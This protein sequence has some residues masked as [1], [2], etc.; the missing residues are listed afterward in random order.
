[1]G[2]PAATLALAIALLT[3][4]CVGASTETTP[5]IAGSTSTTSTTSTTI[6]PTTTTTSPAQTVG[7]EILTLQIPPGHPGITVTKGDASVDRGG[8]DV[9]AAWDLDPA[10][11]GF[12]PPITATVALDGFDGLDLLWLAVAGGG[13]WS[14]APDI[15]VAETPNGA[16][17]TTELPQTGRTALVRGPSLAAWP[18]DLGEVGVGTEADFDVV[19]TS[20]R[21]TY[22]FVTAIDVDLEVFG[23]ATLVS[24]SRD[25][26]MPATLTLRCDDIGAVHTH[27]SIDVT[28]GSSNGTWADALG[29]W[30]GGLQTGLGGLPVDPP[31]SWRI[32][33]EGPG[34]TVDCIYVWTILDDIDGP[35]ASVSDRIDVPVPEGVL[36]ETLTNVGVEPSDCSADTTVTG[37]TRLAGTCGAASVPC[38]DLVVETASGR[39]PG[40]DGPWQELQVEI[41]HADG[42]TTV[43]WDRFLQGR[44]SVG[45]Q[46]LGPRD[47]EVPSA[48][49]PVPG[50]GWLGLIDCEV[51]GN[52]LEVV[53]AIAATYGLP[54][55]AGTAD[56]LRSAYLSAEGCAPPAPP[57]SIS[58]WAFFAE[59]A[60]GRSVRVDLTDELE[61]GLLEHL[62]GRGIWVVELQ[63]TGFSAEE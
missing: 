36:C 1:M 2:R 3:A 52:G 45:C 25:G 35:M 37:I 39:R 59:E 22:G 4:G 15:E 61:N 20:G 17:V 53:E 49:L 21:S 27:M 40:P 26:T 16:L 48:V 24:T 8:V 7:D 54:G 51:A 6:A 14:I 47:A 55:T 60:G 23:P 56:H 10:G 29:G 46:T 18:P 33:A 12:E 32:T 38:T 44:R 58:L 13:S 50:D 31:A 30:F 63:E 62:T 11:T 9:V 34:P 28:G 57:A 19:T 43:C 42:L 41:V 5:P